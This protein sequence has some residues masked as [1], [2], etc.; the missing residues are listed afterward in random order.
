MDRVRESL[1]SISTDNEI[2]I[3]TNSLDPD[4]QEIQFS[5]WG[6][7]DDD[8]DELDTDTETEPATS[9]KTVPGEE[10]F[11]DEGK[12]GLC[13]DAPVLVPI[14]L[15]MNSV[16]KKRLT[17]DWKRVTE[18]NKLVKLPAQPNAVS[19]LEGFVRN[20]AIQRLSTHEKKS[21]RSKYAQHATQ[22]K[23]NLEHAL[24]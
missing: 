21:G 11:L 16:L 10:G 22:G 9:P 8:D 14:N 20:Y 19:V 2:M 4:D 15:P 24:Q 7:N 6:K 5:R 18:D 23:E 13:R 1:D 3:H 17:E 12:D